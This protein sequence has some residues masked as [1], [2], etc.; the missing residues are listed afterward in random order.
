MFCFRT[1]CTVSRYD[2]YPTTANSAALG[3]RSSVPEEGAPGWPCEVHLGNSCTVC[4]LPW[5]PLAWHLLAGAALPS[6]KPASCPRWRY[7]TQ[8]TGE[9][10]YLLLAQCQGAS[11]RARGSSK[12][13]SANSP[14]DVCSRP[15]STRPLKLDEGS[16][17]H[18]PHVGVNKL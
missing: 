14:L 6:I 3:W 5:S 15:E 8:L 1:F 12:V 17:W 9:Y 2:D 11:G 4:R 16:A 13:Q 10:D 18:R 7:R